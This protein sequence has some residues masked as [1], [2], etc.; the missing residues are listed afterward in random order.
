MGI[1]LKSIEKAKGLLK[2]L[3][4]SDNADLDFG[5]YRIMNFKRAEIEK[6]IEK[7][8]IEAVRVEFQEY[9]KV[10][11]L[12]LEK[13][14]A[15]IKRQI[16]EVAPGTIDD[17][18][19]VT[20]NFDSP[21]VQE[22]LRI[23]EDYK[24]ASISEE[25]ANDVFNHV[26]D[27]FSRYYEDG[28]FIPKIRYGGR[29]KYFVP[30]NGEEV[31]L[32]WATKDMYYVK[33]SEYFNKYS[34]KAG[35]FR[36]TFKLVE[37]QVE[38]GNVKGDKKFFMLHYEDPITF[39]DTSNEVEIRFNYRN[40]TDEEEERY[41]RRTSAKIQEAL[42]D[43]ALTKIGASLGI[44]PISGI[45]RPQGNDEKSLTRKHLE[46]YVERNTKDFFIHKDLKGF[47]SKE[48]E[49][50][51]KNEAWNL[52][53]LENTST[54]QTKLMMA[55]AKAIRGIS[56]K[57]IEILAQIED[58]QRRLFEKKKFVLR[59]DYCITLDLIP[60]DFYEEI[61]KNKNQVKEWMNLF[62]F[63][64]NKEINKLKGKLTKHL[65]N[66]GE[67]KIE[68][69]KHNPTL[70]IDTK[71]YDV[72]FKYKII[73]E[74]DNIDE[75][76]T[77]KLIK[78]ENFQSLKLL[79][80]KFKEKIE[81][82][83]IDP[84]YNTGGDEFLYKDNYQHSSWLSM[85]KDRLEQIKA[86][87]SK[88]G[89]IFIS[90]GQ[91]EIDNLIK[92]C[93]SVF[94]RYNR[95]GIISRIM[96]TGGS[97][98]TFFSPNIE[99]ILVYAKSI[100]FADPFR[101]KLSEELIEKV[102][103]QMETKGEAK[104]ERYRIMGLYQAGLDI[105]PNQRYWIKCSDGSYAIPPG[106]TFPKNV[107]E[108]ELVKPIA[109]DGVWRWTFDRYKKELKKNNIVFKETSTSSLVTPNGQ[110]SKWNIYT[111]IWL[112]DRQE[113]G[114]VPVDIITKYE[115]R[116][117]SAELKK[118]GIK[119]SFA[120]PTGLIK[121]LVEIQSSLPQKYII[122]FFA[123]SGTT[124]HSVLNLNKEDNGKRKFILVEMG[125][126]FD[127]VLK[128]RI[129]KVVYSANW[130][131]GKPKDNNGSQKQ[132]IKYQY[133]EQYEDTL[134]NIEFRQKNEYIQRRLDRLPDYFLT[135]ILDYETKDS[136]TRISFEQFNTPFNYRIKIIDEGKEKEE[137]VDLVETFNYLL[138]LHVNRLRSFING[139]QLYRVVYGT[140][141]NE[142]VVV[143]WR[144]TPD[145]NL[146]QDKEFIEN[147][148][149]ADITPDTIYINGDSYLEN[150]SPI[151]PEFK[152]L[153]GA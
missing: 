122:D 66:D 44:S 94:N 54:S 131:G 109:N 38:Q 89:V 128:P 69:L 103:T 148:V 25:Q 16:N 53:A 49:F 43:E 83:Y 137:S 62:S 41:S 9:A 7:D 138:G 56:T 20:K 27:F 99:Y 6:F 126:Y 14:V 75:K 79:L 39:S 55:K 12:E 35:R 115:N 28:D 107:K 32:H 153:M 124:G 64:I 121:Y 30:Y 31:L 76:I 100:E 139:D 33:T 95:I 10:S 142:Q 96:K 118:L 21:K 48:L 112:K 22:Y 141:G 127:T 70:V 71:F 15:R 150:A 87:L 37:V 98:G 86:I 24:A 59:T 125:Q 132:I 90:I 3:F 60:E 42:I 111:K 68:I 84:P 145:L 133:L 135:Y 36:V 4:R 61:G 91:E 2:Q 34:F 88:E 74:I 117:S 146:K 144:N 123:G 110:N 143:I 149:L 52:K 45:L 104:G 11:S 57:I 8:L 29:D 50:Y 152:R 5:I 147:T 92:L 108:G 17:N 1:E 26:Y 129:L 65:K 78:S 80:N 151:E 77:G 73:S 72:E 116:H 13:E 51:L 105:R 85:K 18:G 140:R 136:P 67:K 40:L 93:D 97:K 101:E 82:C 114:R 119:Y 102:Y 63:D 46:A 23:I 81:F 58:F 19:N 113:S 106:N 130:E 47:L 134:N 120:K